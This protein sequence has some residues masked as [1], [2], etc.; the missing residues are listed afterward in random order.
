M[1]LTVQPRRTPFL[2][3]RRYT[4][5]RLVVFLPGCTCREDA[6]LLPI[7]GHDWRR[8]HSP[9]FSKKTGLASAGSGRMCTR[10]SAF[11][12]AGKG[13]LR[14][15]AYS[16]CL[17]IPEHSG[18]PGRTQVMAERES[19]AALVRTSIPDCAVGMATC[20]NLT[21]PSRLRCLFQ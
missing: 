18:G 17:R 12:Y 2:P 8:Y 20:L 11:Q 4:A 6:A 10:S 21:H 14:R 1:E 5:Q 9:G 15:A 16:V 3:S 7:V 13:K 19:A